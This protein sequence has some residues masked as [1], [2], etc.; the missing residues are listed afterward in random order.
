MLSKDVEER[1]FIF[2]GSLNVL[3]LVWRT[4]KPTGYIS[5]SYKGV[6]FEVASKT[7]IFFIAEKYNNRHRSQPTTQILSARFSL[8]LALPHTLNQ[9]IN[10]QTSTNNNS[11]RFHIFESIVF[12]PNRFGKTPLA[13]SSLLIFPSFSETIIRDPESPSVIRRVGNT[14]S[15]YSR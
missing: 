1:Q 10:Q 9:S 6:C 14:V 2:V 4:R 15:Y 5:P 3:R 11:K 13:Y 12:N 8:P 7:R